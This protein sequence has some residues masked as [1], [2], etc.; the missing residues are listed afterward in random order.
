MRDSRVYTFEQQPP[1]ISK[2]VGAQIWSIAETKEGEE[3][4]GFETFRDEGA[5][6]PFCVTWPSSPLSRDPSSRRL[7]TFDGVAASPVMLQMRR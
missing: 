4:S 2:R 5:T 1:K 6:E 7:R 3:S